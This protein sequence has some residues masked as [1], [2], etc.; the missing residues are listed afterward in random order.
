M[1]LYHYKAVS[2]EGV[3]KQGRLDALSR[4]ELKA[5]LRAQGLSLISYSRKTSFLLSRKVPLRALIDLCLH[6]QQFEK[7]GISLKDSLEEL[8]SVSDSLRLK[9]TLKIVIKD[10]EGGLILSKALMKHPTVFDAVFVG[11]I[12]VG[13][14]TGR[15]AFVLEHLS[16]HYKWVDETQALTFKALRY[17]LIVSLVLM[18]LIGVL[19]TY[20]VPELIVFI[21]NFS[22][23]LPLSTRILIGFSRFLSEN[24]VF[25]LSTF[26]ILGVCLQ[27][28]L[29][30]HPKGYLG[31]DLF[32]NSLPVIGSLRRRLILVRFLHIF[33][34]LFESGIDIISALQISR[35]SLTPGHMSRGLLDLERQIQEGLTLS[36]AFEKSD[37]FPKMALHMIRMGEQTSRLTE[38][39]QHAKDYLDMTLKRQIEMVIG[40][41]EPTLILCVG[42]IIGWIIYALL[43]PLYD[44]LSL[45]EP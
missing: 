20:L 2:E 19:M 38:A 18:F 10:I 3:L 39:L 11:M 30:L 43:L 33:T 12:T 40:L 9:S 6:I 35:K 16:Q 21:Q 41:I 1:T 26:G 44:T 29:K 13:E 22:N 32:L 31:K 37:N 4:N 23:D 27:V 45:L 8:A 15:I 28:I 14:K 7:A 34:V 5:Q 25:L 24:S 17:P 42:C 36:Q